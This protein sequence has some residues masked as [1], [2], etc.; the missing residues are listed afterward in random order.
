M[1]DIIIQGTTG[2]EAE[3]AM[4]ISQKRSQDQ[5]QRAIQVIQEVDHQRRREEEIR[6]N[7]NNGII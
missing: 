3:T 1:T 4:T 6:K 5:N 2:A 7:I